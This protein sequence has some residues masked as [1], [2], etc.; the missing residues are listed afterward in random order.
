MGPEWIAVC[1]F[2]MHCAAKNMS[3]YKFVGELSPLRNILQL[4]CWRRKNVFQQVK[5]SGDSNLGLLHR[6]AR[7]THC[8]TLFLFLRPQTNFL[9]AKYSRLRHKSNADKR[10]RRVADQESRAPTEKSGENI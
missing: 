2:S 3:T 1:V 7:G 6:D 4:A 9:V 8:R 10:E 5:S